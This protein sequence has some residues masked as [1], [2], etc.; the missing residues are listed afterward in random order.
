MSAP[1]SFGAVPRRLLRALHLREIDYDDFAILC[2]L[3]LAE[4]HR[5][6][7]WIGQAARMAEELGWPHTLGHLVKTLKSLA[8]RG[9]IE[10][11]AVSGSRKPYPIRLLPKA[12]RDPS[13]A[14]ARP[15]LGQKSPSPA[16][17]SSAG[18][19]SEDTANTL[20]DG[21][22]GS[23]ELSRGRAFKK[24]TAA[25]EED[26]DLRP[27]PPRA[28]ESADAPV[29][30]QDLEIGEGTAAAGS[31]ASESEIRTLVASLKGHDRKSLNV[32]EPLANG[33]TRE[34]FLE[35]IDRAR[36][37]RNPVGWL[38]ERL[39]DAGVEERLDRQTAFAAP[40]QASVPIERL[41]PE[42]ALEANVRQLAH[43]GHSWEAIAEHVASVFGVDHLSA[44]R[45]IYDRVSEAA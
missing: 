28:R 43:N 31:P 1:D 25:V 18:P 27:R 40:V 22:S 13:S 32:V 6:G 5:T 7:E 30:D 36:T 29:E 34:T 42:Q 10:S 26:Q 11:G 3:T 19:R 24:E 12:R 21:A 39:R 37:A 35:L 41:S 44:A 17:L 4:D 2:Y 9:W 33:V 20:H 38:V 16:E 15:E 14:G 45:A 8:D 23:L